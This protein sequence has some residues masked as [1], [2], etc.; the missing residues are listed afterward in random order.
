MSSTFCG[1]LE[2][3]AKGAFH[4]GVCRV[5]DAKDPGDLA[6]VRRLGIHAGE[7]CTRD[8]ARPCSL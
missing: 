8:D 6:L 7:F 2:I 4:L 5:C 3:G 1:A